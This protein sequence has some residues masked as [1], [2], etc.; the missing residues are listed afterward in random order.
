MAMSERAI[1]SSMNED[2][3]RLLHERSHWLGP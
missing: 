1:L 2:F 3:V